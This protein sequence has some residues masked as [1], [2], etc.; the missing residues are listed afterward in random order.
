[1]VDKTEGV[2]MTCQGCGE[3]LECHMSNYDG[4]FENKLQWQNSNGSAHYKWAGK[5]EDGSSKF[6]CVMMDVTTSTTSEP[7][8]N[9]AEDGPKIPLSQIADEEKITKTTQIAI[10]LDVEA[11]RATYGNMSSSDVE[12]L[13]QQQQKDMSIAKSVLFKGMVEIY[14]AV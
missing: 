3:N 6:K 12:K 5:N 2:K 14:K 13:S 9:T 7:T 11:K 10:R 8:T 4:D 1:M